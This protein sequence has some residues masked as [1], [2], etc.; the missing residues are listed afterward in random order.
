MGHI[1]KAAV[2]VARVAGSDRYIYQGSPLPEGVKN[3]DHLIAC[4][5]VVE[6]DVVGEVTNEEVAPENAGIV[7]DEAGVEHVGETTAD[8]VAEKPV[9]RSAK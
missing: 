5:L 3:L 7:V 4:D 1:V 6:A 9:R 2:A 8:I